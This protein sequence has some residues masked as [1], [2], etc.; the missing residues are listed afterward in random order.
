[1]IVHSLAS[2]VAPFDANPTPA[3]NIVWG[4]FYDIRRYGG[5]QILLRAVLG[6]HS[7]V[8]S[9]VDESMGDHLARLGHHGV[10]HLSGTP[11]HWR[12][13]LM[14]TQSPA[15]SPS[16]IRLSGEI[17]DQGILSS[18]HATYPTS[19]IGHAFASTEAGVVFEVN[20]GLA[21]FPATVVGKH[22]A[23]EVKIMDDTLRVR[24]NRTA[25]RYMDNKDAALANCDG[26]VDTGDMVQLNEDRYRFIG[27]RDCVINIGGLKVSPEEV[28]A[29]INSHPAVQISV[30]RSRKNPITGSIVSADIVLKKA[31]STDV[32]D[33]ARF[34]DEILEVCRQSLPLHKV[35]VTIRCVPALEIAAG[36]KLSRQHA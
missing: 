14:S 24:S 11:S 34:M 20:D 3:T 7:L 9:H 10:T 19:I 12:N 13:V 27:R 30:V 22:G 16:Y 35:P 29:V 21:G 8:L 17:A 23:V 6:G 33:S 28:E 4:T 36:G 5:L 15:I 31:A 26:F 25:L 32:T 18:L 2:L 1:M